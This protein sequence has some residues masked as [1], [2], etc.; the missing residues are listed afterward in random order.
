MN[1]SEARRHRPTS[2]DRHGRRRR[3]SQRGLSVLEFALMLPLLL[4]FVLA[5]IDLGRYVL[6]TQRA[7]AAAAAAAELASQTETFT[8]EMNI[9][10]VVTG[11]EIAVLAVAATE[12]ARPVNLLDDGV[13]VVTLVANN[14][15]GAAIAWQRRW[16]QGG[17]AAV[18]GAARMGGVTLASGEA[19]VFAEVVCAFRPWLLSGRLLGLPDRW[20][21]RAVSVRRPRLGGPV[22][23]T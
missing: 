3:R 2:G 17:Q 13:L 7:A 20:T 8:P 4:G 10:N 16:G 22:I 18:S 6:T 12:V 14:G 23:G 21:Y 19:A 9:A 15:N 1:R 5:V 11:R